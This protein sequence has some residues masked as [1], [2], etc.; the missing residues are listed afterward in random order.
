MMVNCKNGIYSIVVLSNHDFFAT[1]CL[2]EITQEYQ[3]KDIKITK[4]M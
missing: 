4:N 1:S 2:D 3:A